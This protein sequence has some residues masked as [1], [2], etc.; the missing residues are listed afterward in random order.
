[1]FWER[2]SAKF[3]DCNFPKNLKTVVF[4]VNGAQ[5]LE[6]QDISEGSQG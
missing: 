2:T 4:R 1:M 5:A 3:G 6:V